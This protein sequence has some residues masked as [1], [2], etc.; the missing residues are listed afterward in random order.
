VSYLLVGYRGL[1]TAGGMDLLLSSSSRLYC[2]ASYEHE[3]CQFKPAGVAL[4][5]P[6][7]MAPPSRKFNPIQ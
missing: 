3:T 1:D 7:Q 4:L 5:Q 2:L 6:K